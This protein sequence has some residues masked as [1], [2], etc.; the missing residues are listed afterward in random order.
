MKKEKLQQ[1]EKSMKC[2]FHFGELQWLSAQPVKG[3]RRSLLLADPKNKTVHWDTEMATCT[4]KIEKHCHFHLICHIGQGS[5]ETNPN[6]YCCQGWQAT[7]K[8]TRNHMKRA[9]REVQ[10]NKNPLNKL[11]KTSFLTCQW[12]HTR[13]FVQSSSFKLY[14]LLQLWSHSRLMWAVMCMSKSY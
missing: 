9:M 2:H 3:S 11:L 10:A 4:P 7:C 6:R 12:I 8:N 5:I 13:L 1:R 14:S